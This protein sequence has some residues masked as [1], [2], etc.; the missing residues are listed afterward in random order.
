MVTVTAEP[1]QLVFLTHWQQNVLTLS[2]TGLQNKQ[3][4]KTMTECTDFH[5]E[6]FDDSCWS[7][8][9]KE[10]PAVCVAGPC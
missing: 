5:F 10:Q 9:F 8:R 2:L 7:L 6:L 3:L 1:A 4:H